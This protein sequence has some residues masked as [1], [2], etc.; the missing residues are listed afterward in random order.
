MFS[1]LNETIDQ[2]YLAETNNYK[3]VIDDDMFCYKDQLKKGKPWNYYFED[4]FD[5]Q[6]LES[7]S[8]DTVILPTSALRR[9]NIIAPRR[10]SRMMLPTDR[11]LAKR[12]IDK[13]IKLKGDIKEKIQAYKDEHFEGYVIG[14]HLRGPG[15]LD[16]G[17][18]DILDELVLEHKVP[19]ELYF[20]RVDYALG[21]HPKA[22]ILLCTDATVVIDECVKRYGDKIFYT[23]SLR[24]I[25]GEM[26]LLWEDYKYDLGVDVLV[27]A[28][29][30]CLSDFFIHSISNVANFVVCNN[31]DLD[32]VSIL[33]NAL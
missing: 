33:P 28:Y 5:T 16:D 26:H 14:L 11:H 30:L 20:R 12:V 15:K 23:D 27:D 31:P 21:K 9:H 29:L 6:P 4:C 32:H 18:R 10:G 17:I 8:T 2:L 25:E 13:Y 22:K 19:Y 3:F 1:I 7:L 24:S